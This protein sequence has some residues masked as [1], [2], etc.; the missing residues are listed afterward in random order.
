MK[1]I[2]Q[3]LSEVQIVDEINTFTNKPR[4][5]NASQ[6]LCPPDISF[7]PRYCPTK[8][9]LRQLPTQPIESRKASK[10]EFSSRSGS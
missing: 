10:P 8:P 4:Y 3:A 1:Q 2:V 5:N 7:A 6:G 9:P